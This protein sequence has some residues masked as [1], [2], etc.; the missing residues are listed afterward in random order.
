[1]GAAPPAEGW[2]RRRR[3]GATLLIF[4]AGRTRRSRP[5]GRPPNSCRLQNGAG[6]QS[7]AWRTTAQSR[8]SPVEAFVAH[9]SVLWVGVKWGSQT[10]LL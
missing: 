3:G 1:M 7:P 8:S 5:A 4:P 10:L 9:R 2:V 6:G